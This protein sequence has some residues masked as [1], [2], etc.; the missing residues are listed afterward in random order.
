MILTEVQFLTHNVK[1]KL[2]TKVMDKHLDQFYVAKLREQLSS[3]ILDINQI[4]ANSD[5]LLEGLKTKYQDDEAYKA[6]VQQDYTAQ[7]ELNCKIIQWQCKLHDLFRC[8]FDTRHRAV[9]RYLQ[10]LQKYLYIDNRRSE[11]LDQIVNIMHSLNENDDAT[12]EPRYEM[13]LAAFY[14]IM[15]TELRA[16][17]E[18]LCNSLP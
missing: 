3:N 15:R 4:N 14:R 18:A 12:V 9:L 16:E 13:I 2:G 6:E 11:D 5:V 17:V 10:E 7:Q 8:T 1:T